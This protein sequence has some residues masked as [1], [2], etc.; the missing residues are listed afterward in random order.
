[1]HQWHALDFLENI[2]INEEQL[3]GIIVAFARSHGTSIFFFLA[4]LFGVLILWNKVD[5]AALVSANTSLKIAGKV[6]HFER[7]AQGG[8]RAVR[9]HQ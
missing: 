8:G 5:H 2:G 6:E 9:L 4:S 7:S 1:M 3:E